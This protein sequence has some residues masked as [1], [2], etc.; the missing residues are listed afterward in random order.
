MGDGTGPE[1]AEQSTEGQNWRFD[2]DEVGPEAT[3]SEPP[4]EPEPITLE[5]AA[6]FLL[7][8]GLFLALVAV[9]LF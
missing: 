6:F 8:I 3:T 7:G 4:L 9:L 5:H 2:L 1:D